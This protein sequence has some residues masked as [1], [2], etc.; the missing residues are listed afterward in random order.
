MDTVPQHKHRVVRAVFADQLS[1]ALGND[2]M[3]LGP[4]RLRLNPQYLNMKVRGITNPS[5]KTQTEKC[6]EKYQ[7]CSSTCLSHVNATCVQLSGGPLILHSFAR[8]VASNP[9]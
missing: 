4:K 5:E 1:R 6:V 8:S 2:R 7:L 9:T 3:S